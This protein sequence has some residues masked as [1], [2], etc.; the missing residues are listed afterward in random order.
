MA[1]STLTGWFSSLKKRNIRDG[2]SRD[3]PAVLHYLGIVTLINFFANIE[4]NGQE[5]LLASVTLSV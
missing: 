2:L 3:K 4:V 5:A 1:F